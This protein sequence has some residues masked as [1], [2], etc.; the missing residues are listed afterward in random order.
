MG[1]PAGRRRRDSATRDL[2]SGL[3]FGCE[4]N[5]SFMPDVTRRVLDTQD[6]GEL[7]ATD[8]ENCRGRGRGRRL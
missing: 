3:A 8:V 2:G 1:L 4:R 6:C 7:I 5:Q